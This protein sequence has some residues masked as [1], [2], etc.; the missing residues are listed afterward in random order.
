MKALFGIAL[1]AMAISGCL[2]CQI[3]PKPMP[4]KWLHG[5]RL[6]V[7]EFNFSVS[8]PTPDSQWSYR[9]DLPKVDGSTVTAFI[10]TAA[11]D[12]KYVVM[13][14][15]RGGK[16]DST[17]AKQ[18]I[19]GMQKSMPKDWQV[20]D[21]RLEPT[22]V[23][24][25]DS[26][27]LKVA[28]RLSDDATLYA[29][30]YVVG[31]NRTYEI[32]SYSTESTEPPAFSRFVQSFT[33]ISPQANAPPPSF[34]GFFLLWAIWGAIADWR[35]ISRGGVERTRNETIGVLAAIGISIV[36]IVLFSVLGAPPESLGEMTVLFVTL[37]FGLW[38]FKRWRIRQKNPLPKPLPGGVGK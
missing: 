34:L 18:F 13:V 31:G 10:V 20:R 21:A 16:V 19:A 28:Y 23:P 2:L 22:D 38:E 11:A 29:Y 35:Y 7:P 24:V 5:G 30:G 4:T 6:V 17:S 12:T 3:D 36:A 15:E 1:A 33:L 8:S 14:L 9:D 25:K 37:I 26:M 27:K 32:L